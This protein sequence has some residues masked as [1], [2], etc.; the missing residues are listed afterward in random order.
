MIPDGVP[1]IKTTLKIMQGLVKTG[2]RDPY[3]RTLSAELVLGLANKDFYGEA[4]TIF[5][6]VQSNVRYIQDIN[7][8]E[9]LYPAQWTLSNGYGDCDDFSVLMASMLESIGHKCRF[10][11]I[12]FEGPEDFS[13]VLI[14]T[15]IGNRWITADATEEQ[16]FGWQPPGITYWLEWYI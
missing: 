16:P 5:A 2:R 4:E 6:Y 12:S 9:T 11:A 1:G 3:I 10:M 15:K 14:Q 7:D 8:V 13:H